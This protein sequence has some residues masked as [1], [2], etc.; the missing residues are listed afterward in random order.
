MDEQQ[1]KKELQKTY[2]ILLSLM[3]GGAALILGGQYAWTSIQKQFAKASEKE[4]IEAK[5]TEV[6]QL[7]AKSKTETEYQSNQLSSNSVIAS[8]ND[9]SLNQNTNN[10]FDNSQFPLASCGDNNPGG[11]NTWH[12]V[13]IANTQQNLALARRNY[14]RDA[15]VTFRKDNGIK[16]IQVASFLSYSKARDFSNL[17]ATTVYG[18][19]VGEPVVRNLDK[20]GSYNNYSN[21]NKQ[22]KSSPTQFV[23]DHYSYLGQRQYQ[24][25]WNRLSQNFRN[26]INS[27]SE[28][29][30]WWHSVR[31]IQIK[32][33]YLIEE[34][35]NRAIVHAD[36]VY[37]LNNGK[38]YRDPKN[39]IYLIWDSRSQN[40]SIDEKK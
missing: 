36:L 40:W 33:V 39:K 5:S 13:Y 30:K 1:R 9:R 7:T 35:S 16:A 22:Q 26:K 37:Y 19:E 21:N 31:Q 20:A 24:T 8:N 18:S 28:Y 4:N 12:P 15:F 6:S 27:Y 29:T 2:F 11:T 38:S 14:C 23:K 34:S 10:T 32:Q 25:S 3:I 17:I